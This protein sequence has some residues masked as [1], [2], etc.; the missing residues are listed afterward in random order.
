MLE[1]FLCCKLS[2]E[3]KLLLIT[4]YLLLFYFYSICSLSVILHLSS[5][6]STLFNSFA[7]ASFVF[8]ALIN[9]QVLVTTANMNIKIDICRFKTTT[10]ET[11]QYSYTYFIHVMYL[12]NLMIHFLCRE[13]KKNRIWIF[14]SNLTIIFY[15][16]CNYKQIGWQ[17]TGSTFLGLKVLVFK[18]GCLMFFCWKCQWHF[19]HFVDDG[20]VTSVGQPP[21]FHSLNPI[22]TK[23]QETLQ[24]NKSNYI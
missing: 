1:K 3:N 11:C 19:V 14:F 6:Q 9:T 4:Y 2:L 13:L 8:K 5:P 16:Y 17:Y 18:K 22:Y 7:L 12:S 20:R 10:Q 15:W 23:H 24:K 21:S